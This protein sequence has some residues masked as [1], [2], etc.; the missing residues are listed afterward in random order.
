MRRVNRKKSP[1]QQPPEIPD[2]FELAEYAQGRLSRNRR[3]EIREILASGDPAAQGVRLDLEEIKSRLKAMPFKPLTSRLSREMQARMAAVLNHSGDPMPGEIWSLRTQES[4]S[5]FSHERSVFILY[6][7]GNF[8]RVAPVTREIDF[9]GP[10]DII[11]RDQAF[12]SVPF[13]LELFIPFWIDLA[14]LVER[15]EFEA[16]IS[17]KILTAARQADRGIYSNLPRAIRRGSIQKISDIEEF[18]EEWREGERMLF[19][20]FKTTPYV[21]EKFETADV[22]NEIE[23]QPI[24]IPLS[25]ISYQQPTQYVYRLAAADQTFTVSEFEFWEKERGVAG[26]M[27]RLI[28]RTPTYEVRVSVV[29]G[30]LF[31]IVERRDESLKRVSGVSLAMGSERIST[32]EGSVDFI[33]SNRVHLHFD[34]DPTLQLSG[35]WTLRFRLDN[36]DYE[37]EVE[38]Q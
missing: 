14:L 7:R 10:R 18:Y 3:K 23:L 35:R 26:G 31:F 38:F 29:D 36:D 20:R 1:G 19:E 28:L 17:D 8:A 27:R 4:P 30:H 32:T 16:R 13:T 9:A 5:G 12:A 33:S 24:I 22:E 34:I 6:V 37:K 2:R 15:A 25:S 21:L 11:V